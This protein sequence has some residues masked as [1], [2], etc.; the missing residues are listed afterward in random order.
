[1]LRC[2][3]TLLLL[4]VTLHAAKPNVLFLF[5]D[6]FT[7]EA[8]RAFGHTEI[9]TPNIDRL[10]ARG[11]TFTRAYNMGSWSGAVCVASRMMLNTGRSVWD[12]G[13]VYKTTDKERQSGVLWSQLM[14]KAGYKTYMTGKWH[15]QTDAT[16][17]F[18]MAMDVRPGMPKT[19]PTSYNRP[20]A[21]QTDAW[22]PYDK[23]LGGFWEGGKH[24]SEVVNDHTI[25]FLND[26][27]QQEKPF[28]IYSAFNA[29]HD[30][31]QAPK[32]FQDMY[33]LSRIKVPEN[34]IPEYPYKDDIGCSEKLRDEHLAPMP[35]TEFAVKTHRSEYYALI[36][37]L[38]VQIGKILD[39]LDANGQADN[40]WIFFTADHGL[41]VGHHGLIGKQNMYDHSVRVPFIVAGP[42]VA[43][44][45]KNDN[46]IYLQDVMATALDL[47]EAEKP[48]HVFFHSLR[49]LLNGTQK[50]SSYDSVYG[51]YL[52]LQ[53]AITHDGW[54]L[55]AYPKAK[56]LRL[57]HLAEDSQEMTD[58]A[59]KPE[60]AA[61]KKEMY[62]RLVK[63]SADLGDQVDL[64]K[65]FGE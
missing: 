55:I 60:H 59:A 33:P 50:H 7:Y 16:K 21:G 20:I 5:A 62:A 15:V 27:K 46:A 52:E 25:T 54:K 1:M 22:S 13:A 17:V 10:A 51:A 18:D 45:A 28:F 57:Y 41:A 12:A 37:H 61:L 31:R 42:G 29:P 44:G 2:I 23:S 34:F 56:V 39:A 40:T 26:A 32:E 65:V 47:A 24:W 9:D 35:R 49:P 3:T 64:Q 8:V 14:S 38:D 63:L 36:T 48:Q 19:V 4:S 58:L 6:D 11:T 43:K 30:P 53:R